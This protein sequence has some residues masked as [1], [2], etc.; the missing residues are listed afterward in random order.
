MKFALVLASLALGVASA[1]ASHKKL[2]GSEAFTA[3]S[4]LSRPDY[5][6]QSH[7]NQDE[8]DENVN[9]SAA[10]DTPSSFY[11]LNPPSIPLAVRGP[12]ECLCVT[13]TVSGKWG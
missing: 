6:E 1:Q 13:W 2:T 3:L 10:Q 7:A 11:P 4:E 9:Y 12:C 5:L 8:T